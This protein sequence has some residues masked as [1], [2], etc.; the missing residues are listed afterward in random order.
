MSTP[1]NPAP[2]DIST[3]EF[4][5]FQKLIFDLAGIRLSEAKKLLLV[6]RL[7]KRVKQFGFSRFGDY[8]NFVTDQANAQELQTMVDLLTTNE[9]YFFREPKHF[10]FLRQV[11][12]AARGQTFRIWSAAASSGE[13]AYSMA[14]V[15]A[16]VLG[17][18]SWEV[19]GT[20]IS[21][22]VL[23]KAQGGLYPTER[24]DGIPLPLLKKYCLKGINEQEG[25]LLII[26]ELRERVRFLHSNLMS[27]R[28]DLGSFDLIFLRN[29]MIYFD[30]DTKRKVI[31]NLLPYLK[32]GGHFIVGHSESLTGI[33]NDLLA[34]QPTIYRRHIARS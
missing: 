23:A 10:D 17:T 2:L 13:E 7:S 31:A 15:L 33:T 18:A 30:N 5:Q 29:V 14:M 22:R 6:G 20:D 27:P 16:D 11:A 24:I 3:A 25:T 34:I 26:R 8:F 21:S 32:S 19:V 1:P 28:K 4:K 9:T 12:S